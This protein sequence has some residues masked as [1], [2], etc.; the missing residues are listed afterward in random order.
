ML[1]YYT[2][3]SHFD[4]FYAEGGR[5]KNKMQWNN[6]PLIRWVGWYYVQTFYL[7]LTFLRAP[8]GLPKILCNS[9]K[10]PCINYL[11]SRDGS[12]DGTV[13]RA[14]ASHQCGPGLIPSP[15]VT[16]GL[17]LLLVLILAA[18]VF[19]WVLQ[20]SSLHRDLHFQIRSGISG[21]K[22]TL[23][24]CYC[25]IPLSNKIFYL[26]KWWIRCNVFGHT[27]NMS[28]WSLPEDYYCRIQ[29]GGKNR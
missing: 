3:Q 4:R 22:A 26:P 28:S 19:L 1:G 7:L 23:W 24:R 14:L 13:V 17:S 29:H 11:R 27:A 25:K 10:Y 21:Q 20:F 5:S 16:C 2:L 18:R 12:R 9:V 6:K 15:C 8:V